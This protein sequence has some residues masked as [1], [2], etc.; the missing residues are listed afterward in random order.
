MTPRQQIESQSAELSPLEREFR[1]QGTSC[2]ADP[3]ILDL[4]PTPKAT[5]KQIGKYNETGLLGD[6]STF[7]ITLDISDLYSES[8][9]VLSTCIFG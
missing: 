5:Q 6:G 4:S 7:S 2:L 1:R 3:L 8:E 9:G